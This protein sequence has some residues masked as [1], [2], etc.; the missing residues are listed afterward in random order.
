[1]QDY[2]TDET[3]Y[4]LDNLAQ[5]LDSNDATPDWITDDGVL[6][7]IVDAAEQR[8][9]TRG[10]QSAMDDTDPDCLLVTDWYNWASDE[11]GHDTDDTLNQVML[12]VLNAR[13]SADR[14]AILFNDAVV[15][16][17]GWLRSGD[18]RR[19]QMR[20]YV[21]DDYADS[22]DGECWIPR[23]AAKY[24]AMIALSDELVHGTPNVTEAM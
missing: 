11:W 3:A 9:A 10:E 7:R 21:D 12:G 22:D 17:T 15:L 2:Y 5:L 24:I 16:Q 13:A 4:T 14:D 1:M 19:T 18:D 20:T 6:Q 23:N 8:A